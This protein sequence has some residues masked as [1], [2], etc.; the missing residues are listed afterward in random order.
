MVYQPLRVLQLISSLEV[1]GSEKLLLELL[2]ASRDDDRVEFTVVVMNRAINAEMQRRLERMGLNVYYL[3]R[4]EGHKHPKYLWELLKI[5]HRHQISILHAHNFGSKL[6]AVLCKMSHPRLKLAFTIHDTM[7]MP[8]LDARQLWIHRNL[9]DVHIAISKTVA[10]L[11][12]QRGV[13]NYQ[14]I[15]NGINLQQFS[16]PEKFSL[17]QR[18]SLYSFEQKPLRIVQVGRMDYSVKGQDILLEA[19]SQ[20]KRNGLKVHVALMGGVYDYNRQSFLTLQNQVNSLNLN[21]EVE[22]LTNRLDVPEVLAQ[23]ELFVLPSRFEGLGLVVLESMAA[24]LPVIASNI[25]GPRE[26]I[27]DGQNGLLFECGNSDDLYSKIRQLYENPGLAD[28]LRENALKY[29]RQFDI[30]AMKQQY[31]ALYNQLSPAPE[32]YGAKIKNSV[33]PHLERLSDGSSF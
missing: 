10:S 19:L 33:Q 23:N 8:K 4:P 18:L 21:D 27:T 29:V 16:N 2:A 25:D 15:Y 31:Y 5:I 28:Q 7:M 24:G 12:D 26:L 1:G 13:K 9:I 32:H 3:D 30:H 6:W 14:Q 20:C 22:F 11:C 17:T